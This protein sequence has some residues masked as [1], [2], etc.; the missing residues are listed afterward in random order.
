MISIIIPNYNGE[1]YIG[2][3][4]ESLIRQIHNFKEIIIIDNNSSD[5][6]RKIIEHYKKKIPNI[7]V[8]YNIINKGFSIAVNQGVDIASGDFILLLNND[9]EL[10][11]NCINELYNYI[12]KDTNIFSVQAKMIKYYDRKKIDDA[13]DEYTIL[14]WAYQA[15]NNKS[16][17]LYSE[18]REIFSACA[19]AAIYRKSILEQIGLFDENFFA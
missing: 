18:S 1:K 7:I 3:C 4:L 5:N 11:C 13:G 12:Y 6:S 16:S 19:G 10:D 17:K 2:I 15:G 9:V 8:I 14:G